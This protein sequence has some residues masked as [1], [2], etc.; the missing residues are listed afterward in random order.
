MIILSTLTARA[1]QHHTQI[2]LFCNNSAE[3]YGGP[4]HLHESNMT[5]SGS[6]FFVE[7]QAWCGGGISIYYTSDPTINERNYLVFQVLFNI[8]FHANVAK[9]LGGAL[10]ID[11]AF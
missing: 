9:G 6:V 2:V 11:D 7:N 1:S 10:H 3:G 8:L 4:V 5:L